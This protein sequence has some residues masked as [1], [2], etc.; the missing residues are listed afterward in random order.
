MTK[1]ILFKLISKIFPLRY[2]LV[3]FTSE[4]FLKIDTMIIIPHIKE[5]GNGFIS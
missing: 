3:N 4:L 5:N 1:Q 2:E